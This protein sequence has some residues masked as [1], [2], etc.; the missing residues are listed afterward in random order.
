MSDKY[1]LLPADRNRTYVGRERFMYLPSIEYL[2]DEVE[3]RLSSDEMV[4]L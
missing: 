2:R 4:T 3:I 1:K